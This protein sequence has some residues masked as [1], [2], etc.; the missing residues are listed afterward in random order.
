MESQYQEHAEN[1]KKWAKQHKIKAAFQDTFRICLLTVEVQNTFC[2]PGF[3]LF[4]GGRS[5]T[6]AV[7]DNQRLCEFIY[8]NLDVTLKMSSG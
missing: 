6:V 1:V 3:E 5:G 7:D 2:I 4:V 8:R